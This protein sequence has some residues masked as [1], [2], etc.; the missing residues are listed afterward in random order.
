MKTLPALMSALNATTDLAGMAVPPADVAADVE[1]DTLTV[2]LAGELGLAAARDLH[3]RLEAAGW[4]ERVRVVVVDFGRAGRAS[5]AAVAAITLAARQLRGRDKR[6]RLRGLDERQRSAFALAAPG[7]EL[8]LGERV[9]FL[10]SVGGG[11]LSVLDSGRR[12]VDFVTATL[13]ASGAVFTRR[14]SVPLGAFVQQASLVGADALPIVGLLSLLLGLTIAFQSSLQLEQFGA[15]LYLAD[16]VCLSMVRE[17]GPMM[18]AVL[19]SARS[20]SA[21]T[22]E[23]S[24]MNV[25]EEIDAMRTMGLDPFSHLVLPRL[26]ALTL[27]LPSLTLMAIL[28]GMIGGLIISVSMLDMA[29]STYVGRALEAVALADIGHGLG[30][31]VL[32]AWIIGITACAVGLHT[33]GGSQNI[34]RATTRTVVSSL[35]LIIV[36]DSVIA[37]FLAV[38]G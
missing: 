37:T 10:E 9:P 15:G 34:G 19:V 28:L 33:R 26:A 25:R 32:F 30:K 4:D 8:E 14:R 17:L 18:T 21:I 36:T 11:V 2:R 24:S 22:S 13:R 35:F 7:P 16:I 12:L 1:R 38:V 3:A 5:S 6:L 23:L 27:V 29:A 31:S 20:G